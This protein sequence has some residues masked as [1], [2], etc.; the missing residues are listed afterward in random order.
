MLDLH[1]HILPG[2]DD[3]ASDLEDSL[4]IARAAAAD[5]TRV[6]AGTP[7]VRHDYP[8]T[9]AEMERALAEVRSA[10]AHHRIELDVVGGGEID[11]DE[12]ERLSPDE[13]RAFGLAGNPQY[14]LLESPYTGWP[15]AFPEIV[16][17]L[18]A[19]GVTPVIAHP[20]RNPLVQSDNG[21]LEEL[22]R[23]GAIVQVTAASLDGRLG[24]RTRTCARRLLDAELVHLV[25]SDAHNARVR[26]VGLAGAWAAVGD[27]ALAKWLMVDVPGAIVGGKPLPLRPRG[28][29]RRGLLSRLLAR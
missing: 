13:R 20:E 3:G 5:G 17:S 4:A 16:F 25:A 19:S 18:V 28:A 12:L 6:I 1:S 7:H 15:L 21:R 11:L 9:P 24:S 10:L 23:A 14:L 29:R 26:E 2:L 22:V 27:E 8:T